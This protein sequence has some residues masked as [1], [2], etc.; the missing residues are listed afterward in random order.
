MFYS[1]PQIVLQEVPGEISLALSISGC[2]LRCK[3]CHSTD[4][5]ST[6]FGIELNEVEFNRLLAKYRHISCILFYGGEWELDNLNIM[7][8]IAR[9]KNLKIALYSGFDL[10]FFSKDFLKT[11]DYIKVGAYI[12]SLGGLSSKTTNQRFYTINNGEIDKELIFN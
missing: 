1:H 11:L 12:E 8:D 2:P 3:G 7:I 10:S 6:N 4:T 5:Y 9:N